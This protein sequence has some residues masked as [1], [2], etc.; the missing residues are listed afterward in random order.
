MVAE[1]EELP[2]GNAGVDA[3]IAVG[4]RNAGDDEEIAD[5]VAGD[6]FGCDDE[7]IA[8]DVAV[9]VAGGAAALMGIS[10]IQ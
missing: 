7:E 5:D 10:L 4:A 8:V 6:G 2:A 3:T 9:V 1:D